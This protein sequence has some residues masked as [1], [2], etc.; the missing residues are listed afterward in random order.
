MEF[1]RFEQSLR[2]QFHRLY[3]KIPAG[4]LL[5]RDDYD[6]V[7]LVAK[8][9]VL[10]SASLA[11]FAGKI[12]EGCDFVY[13]DCA[14][15]EDAQTEVLYPEEHPEAL[16]L[17]F[18]V[19]SKP[20]ARAV[21]SLGN[22]EESMA[23]LIY[24]AARNARRPAHIGLILYNCYRSINADD[25][26]ARGRERTLVLSHEFS[27]TGAPR[28]L[29]EAVRILK[30]QPPGIV[31]AGPC[32]DALTPLFLKQ[33]VT[34]IL[35]QNVRE[36]SAVTAMAYDCDLVI[37]NTAVMV[38]AVRM[39]CG[40]SVPVL[41][42][43]HDAAAVYDREMSYMD[44]EDNVRVCCVSRRAADTF[45]R[46]FQD[47][48]VSLMPYGIEDTSEKRGDKIRPVKKDKTVFSIIGTVSRRKGQD[49]LCKAVGLLPEEIL[50]EC[51]F[52][53]AGGVFERDVMG[54]IESLSAKYPENVIYAGQLPR[55]KTDDLYRMTDCVLCPSRDD[56]LPTVIT[57]G[58][59]HGK[60]CICS[61]A[62]GSTAYI[63]EGEN[64]LILRENTPEE[65]AACLR[66]TLREKPFAKKE[67][68]GCCRDTYLK[69]FGE[70]TFAANLFNE[71]KNA[72]EACRSPNTTG[73]SNTIHG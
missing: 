70:E 67:V 6:A 10:M 71:I 17:V 37:A 62:V 42:W 35:D 29:L 33:G 11:Y 27:L 72:K 38:K 19:I 73:P 30:K 13:S 15:G 59:M 55:E 69:Y 52:L 5:S 22:F 8:D 24:L 66:K 20:L 61:A 32:Y 46:F 23:D 26:F 58:W 63:R 49:I 3:Y 34:V 31:V 65:W 51:V 68:A 12:R 16:G 1:C 54:D 48:S 50:R 18:A 43:I 56:P 14:Y 39:L 41:W 40:S 7:A 53:F 9:I 45:R 4:E 2:K 64:G 25:V 21:F 60:M 28:V 36:A 57:E 44:L 47:K